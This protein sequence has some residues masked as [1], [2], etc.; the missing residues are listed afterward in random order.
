[1]ARSER[2]TYECDVCG[3]KAEAQRVTNDGQTYFVRPDKW[4]HLFATAQRG[5]EKIARK[6]DF[7]S[8]DCLTSLYDGWYE[9]AYD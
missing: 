2:V 7:C 9:E 6:A 3:R 4:G 5:S 1:M 8:E